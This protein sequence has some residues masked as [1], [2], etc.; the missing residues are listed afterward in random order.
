MRSATMSRFSSKIP[1]CISYVILGVY[2]N[3]RAIFPEPLTLCA[4]RVRKIKGFR[5]MAKV[6]HKITLFDRRFQTYGSSGTSMS[7]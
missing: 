7:Q 1:G 5:K 4:R 2:N 3:M 6:L